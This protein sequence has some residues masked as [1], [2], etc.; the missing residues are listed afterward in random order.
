MMMKLRTAFIA[1]L[2]LALASAASAQT[3]PGTSPLSISKGGTSAATASAARTALGLTI[4]SAVQAWDADLDCLAAL[5]S[6][7]LVVRTGAGTCAVRTVTGTANEITVTNGDGASGAPTLS[8]PSALTFTSKTITGGTYNSPSLVTPAL[9]TPASGVL[10]NATG[11]PVSTGI[12][13]LASGIASWLATATSANLAAAITDETGSGAL[14]FGTSPSLTTPNIGAA[15]ATSINKVTITAPATGATITIPDGVTLT[16]PTSS[17]TAAT[18]GNTETFTGVKTFGSAGAV[19]RLKIAGTTSGSTTLDASATASGTLTLPAATDTLVGRATTDTLTNKTFDTAGTGNLFSINGLAATANTGTGSVVRATSPTLVTPI[20]GA[21]TATTL[22]GLTINSTTGTLAI[23]NSKTLTASNTLTLT[24]TDGTSFAFPGSSDTVVTL[25]ATQTLTNKTLTAPTIAANDNAFTLRDDLDTTKLLQFQLSGLTTGTTRTLTVPDASTTLVGTDTTQTLTNKSIVAS[26]LTGTLQAGQFPALT[27]DVT[28]TAGALATTLATVN[29]NVGSFGS[30]TSCVTVTANAKGLITAISAA[31]CAPAWSSIASKPTTVSGFGITDALT[32][33]NNLSDVSS[34]PTARG[35]SGLNIFAAANVGDANYTIT[36]TDRGVNLTTTLTAVRTLTLPAANAV[37]KGEPIIISD[38]AG[39]INGA[40][41]ITVARAGSDTING[42]SSVSLSTQYGVAMFIS[43]GTSKWTYLV[44]GSGGGG[45][46]GTVTS[47]DATGGVA[48]ASGSPITGTG[49]I[50]GKLTS[51][52]QT[53]T[54]YTLVD[55]DRGKH[56]TLSNAASIAVTLP[57]AGASSQFVSGWFGYVSNIGAGTATITPTTSAING[58]ATLALATNQAALII[59]DGTNYRALIFRTDIGTV[60]EKLSTNSTYYVRADLGAATVSIATPGVWTLA[61]HGLSNDDPVVFSIKPD[62]GTATM[63]IASPAVVTRTSHGYSAGQPIK[64]STTGALPTGVTA[65]TTYYVIASG[66][67]ANTFQFSTSVGGAAVNTSGAQSG[68]HYVEK[69]GALPTGITAGTVYYARNVTTNTFEFAATAG[70]ASIATSGSQN[71]IFNVA[72]GNDNNNGLGATRSGAFLTLQKAYDTIVSNLDLGGKAVTVNVADSLYNSGLAVAQPW[73]GGGSVA[74]QGNTTSYRNVTLN[75]TSSDCFSIT[76]ILGGPL[77]FNG[78]RL[79]T[80]TSG[81]ALFHAG[82][83]TVNF[84][85]IDF[86]AVSGGGSHIYNTA[87]T[88]IVL[89]RNDTYLISGGA[90]QHLLAIEGTVNINVSAL[91]LLN[92]PAFSVFAQATRRGF[93]D[94]EA[95]TFTGSA[96]G[97]RYS[98][99]NNGIIY[100]GGAGANYFP[101]SVAGSTATGGQYN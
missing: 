62:M 77:I 85:K 8:L 38:G 41:T 44:A 56:T 61:A 67:T 46:S 78:F 2:A 39:A 57:Q 92:T 31:T 50:I 90:S 100:V 60:R 9:G 80:T 64:F 30:T 81:N 16:G 97:I 26:Q 27:G 71:G 101:G 76:S 13:G 17:G 86:G 87:V 51:N 98:A 88:A 35:S 94:A 24:G 91:S 55:D 59:S 84:A 40:N 69:S 23:A 72:T 25:S 14:V 83:G 47:V 21:A 20:L 45:G 99:N 89:G 68:T 29:S 65:G 42:V 4:G 58:A 12:S 63:T 95:N 48:T 75:T 5:S 7:G 82:V 11:L 19:G 18:L 15:T 10:T 22:N 6:G 32:A 54:S 49:S 34:K 3:G 1:A 37:N 74:F 73:T 70:G 66:L 33:A 93:V 96:T 28:T 36:A 53:G 79:M 52:A 43:D